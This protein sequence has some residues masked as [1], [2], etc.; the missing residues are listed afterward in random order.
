MRRMNES[1]KSSIQGKQTSAYGVVWMHTNDGNGIKKRREWK[2]VRRKK[3]GREM[4]GN[5][6]AL[7][8]TCHAWQSTVEQST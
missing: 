3:F 1:K 8:P 7:K 6:A 4:M 2:W 5:T